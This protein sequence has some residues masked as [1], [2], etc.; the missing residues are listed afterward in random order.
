MPHFV[1][2][3]IS[4]LQIIY[5]FLFPDSKIHGANMGPSWVLSAPDGPHVGPMNLVMWVA[6]MMPFIHVLGVH[7]VIGSIQYYLYWKWKHVALRCWKHPGRVVNVHP[8]ITD[9]SHN[10]SKKTQENTRNTV[11]LHQ[12]NFLHWI[13]LQKNK[14]EAITHIQ[15][16]TIHIYTYTHIAI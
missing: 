1:F 15:H 14:S 13:I 5:W 12:V 9:I 8:M 11:A 3:S 4:H 16:N 6:F 2:Y 10:Y 7:V